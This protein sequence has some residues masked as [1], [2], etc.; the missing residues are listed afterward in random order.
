M[1][2]SMLNC[3]GSW[4]QLVDETLPQLFDKINAP[5]KIKLKSATIFNLHKKRSGAP[6]VVQS[7]K[8]FQVTVRGFSSS[9]L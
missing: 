4:L 2:V 6:Y 3:C 5:N 8:A 9:N 7:K 1:V